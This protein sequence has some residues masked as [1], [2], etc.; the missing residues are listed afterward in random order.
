MNCT[1]TAKQQE[2][3]LI[4]VYRN[5]EDLSNTDKNFIL[6]DYIKE[7]HDLVLD[8]TKDQTLAYVY[9][10]I[11]PEF[12]S[13]AL[14][15]QRDLRSN[16]RKKGLNLEALDDKAQS[17]ED[18]ESVIS[19][20]I[21]KTDAP[22]KEEIDFNKK[23]AKQEKKKINKGP[24]LAELEKIN[25][26]KEEKQK[27]Q[28][29]EAL[30]NEINSIEH[31]KSSPL[32]T[33]GQEASIDENGVL[34]DNSDPRIK[35]IYDFLPVLRKAGLENGGDFDTLE[36]GG[37]TGFRVT[38]IKKSEIDQSI[39]HQR[40]KDLLEGK[41]FIAKNPT[42]AKKIYENTVEF[43]I[44]DLDGNILYF[45]KNN[46]IVEKEN[47]KPIYYP[48]PI[49]KY[50]NKK[51]K[52]SN[53]IDENK[54][55]TPEQ[56]AKYNNKDT[57]SELDEDYRTEL[58]KQAEEQQQLEIKSLYDL[59]KVVKKDPSNRIPLQITNIS[60][61][62][63]TAFAYKNKLVPVSDINFE[64][65]NLNKSQSIKIA[66]RDNQLKGEKNG[67][68][69]LT[70]PGQTKSI[71]LERV[72]RTKKEADT[73]A[74]LIVNDKLK[75]DG[76]PIESSEKMRLFENQ[77]VTSGNVI[78]MIINDNGDLEIKIR[79]KKL[80][81]S[82]KDEAKDILSKFLIENV[83]ATPEIRAENLKNYGD[84]VF[85][86]NHAEKNLPKDLQSEF[87]QFEIVKN[88]V[89]IKKVDPI[90]Y[91]IDNTKTGLKLDNNGAIPV[92][93][94]YVMFDVTEEDLTKENKNLE[95]QK[96][97]L[98][99]EISEVEKEIAKIE[100][101]GLDEKAKSETKKIVKQLSLDFPKAVNTV[102]EEEITPEEI[103][104]AAVEENIS[105]EEVKKKIVEEVD[106]ALQTRS[107]EDFAVEKKSDS[108]LKK[109]ARRIFTA[110]RN[111]IIA[112]V[113]YTGVTAASFEKGT[114]DFNNVIEHTAD[115]LNSNN[116]TSEYSETFI[117]AASK[118]GL[119]DM[120]VNESTIDISKVKEAQKVKALK[121][122]KDQDAIAKATAFRQYK[123][124]NT[125]FEKIDVVKDSHYKAR[126]GSK[127]NLLSAR[128]QWFNE[129]GFTYVSGA[130]Q[131]RMEDGETI[132]GVEGVAH[133][134]ILDD[135]GI[136]LSTK[137]SDK[138]L[139]AAS[140]SFKQNRIGKD[141][142]IT[143][144][145]P[146]FKRD[147][148]KVTV[149]YKVASEIDS[150]DITITRLH[151]YNFDDIDFK[152]K[153]SAKPFGFHGGG[154][155]A[156]TNKAG[157]G[158]PNFLFTSSGKGAYSRFSGGSYVLIFKDKQGNE[159]VH[160]VSGSLELL[161]K[162]GNDLAKSFGIKTSDIT[163]GIYDAGSYSAKPA[164]N[165][166]GVIETDQYRNYNKIHPHS[167]GALIFPKAPVDPV[168]AS[169]LFLSPLGI[170]R[171]KRKDNKKINNRDLQDLKD[172]KDELQNKLDLINKIMDEKVTVETVS[173]NPANIKDSDPSFIDPKINTDLNDVFGQALEKSKKGKKL[174]FRFEKLLPG[175][176]AKA[177][178]AGEWYNS[179]PFETLFP[180]K[181]AMHVANSNAYAT[182]TKHGV[183]L[184][185]GSSK[186][187]LY[188][189]AWH[190]FS[191]FFLTPEE[192]QSLYNE[193]ADTE[194]GHKALKKFARKQK[195]DVD[196]ISQNTKNLVM[197]EYLAED[198]RK[199]KLSN[200]KK[201][202]GSPIR[203][204][205]FKRILNFF[206]E[207]FGVG[208]IKPTMDINTIGRV[209]EFYD[210]L[211]LMDGKSL[212]N[213]S[214]SQ[215]NMMPGITSL[216]KGPIIPLDK[217]STDAISYSDAILVRK[218]FDSIMSS[219]VDQKVKDIGPH[220]AAAVYNQPELVLPALYQ[221]VKDLF[222]EKLADVESR[223]KTEQAKPSAPVDTQPQTSE[224][225]TYKGFV[226]IKNLK[227]NEDTVFGS[228]QDGFH[229]GGTAGILYANDSRAYKK[230]DIKGKGL[231][232]EVGK[233]KGFQTGT[234]GS[235]Y[236]LQTVTDW[237][238][239]MS[240]P[241]RQV[242]KAEIIEQIK[243]MYDYYKKNSNR[244][245]YVL[246]T[247]EGKN[248]NG[249]TS[250]EMAE[251]FASAGPIPS[252]VI[253]NEDLIAL[254]DITEPVS[255]VVA[256]STKN[257]IDPNKILQLTNQKQILNF[258][259]KNFGEP[260]DWVDAMKGVS[261]DGVVAYHLKKSE[262]LSFNP[263]EFDGN[264]V[265]DLAIENTWTKSS[266]KFSM[267]ELTSSQIRNLV[268][269]AKKYNQQ[270]EIEKNSLGFE[271][272]LDFNVAFKTLI[273]LTR[274]LDEPILMASKLNSVGG[275]KD[276][277]TW[278]K[279]NVLSKLG[280]VNNPRYSQNTMNLWTN[281]WQ[282][283]YKAYV[284]SYQLT[285]EEVIER[286]N[287]NT[288]VTKTTAKFGRAQG[289][290]KQVRFA[291]INEFKTTK[292]EF[293]I[294][295]EN[296]ANQLDVEGLKRKYKGST[297]NRKVEFLKDIGLPITDN[298][299]IKKGIDKVN[300]D[301]LYDKIIDYNKA[302]KDP[303]VDIVKVLTDSYPKAKINNKRKAL[304]S[305]ST[306]MNKLYDLEYKY[307]N[308]YG[309]DAEETPDGNRRYADV[310]NSTLTKKVQAFNKAKS[311]DD[312]VSMPYMSY[313]DPA[314]NTLTKNGSVWLNTIFEM[315]KPGK[316][317]RKDI[318]VKL[319]NVGGTILIR[320][321]SNDFD[322]STTSAKSDKFTRLMQDIYGL[323]MLGKPS[324]F[325]PADKSTVLTTSLSK[326]EIE[327]DKNKVS[328]HLY[329]DTADFLVSSK[330]NEVLSVGGVKAKNILINYIQAEIDRIKNIELG[331]QINVKGVTTDILN[332]DGTVKTKARAKDFQIFDGMFSKDVKKKLL[333]LKIPLDEYLKKDTKVSKNLS[334]LIDQQLAGFIETEVED[335]KERMGDL[336][337]FDS[338]IIS[339]LNSMLSQKNI[340]T[341]TVTKDEL[342]TYKRQRD[343]G[344]ISLDKYNKIVN[345]L[346]ATEK[347]VKETALLESYVMNLFI[348]NV[349]LLNFTFG[350]L[351][352]YKDF[353]KRNPGAQS[354]G[355][356]FRN[357]AIAQDYINETMFNT[358][359]EHFR[360]T[361]ANK[362]F[363][364]LSRVWDGVL[365][366]AVV[367][368]TVVES[369]LLPEYRKAFIDYYTKLYID[370]KKYTEKEALAKAKLS[371]EKAVDAYKNME[372]GDGQGWIT[373]DAYKMLSILQ[374]KW[375]PEQDK[376][377]NEIIAGKQLT[378]TETA[379]FFPARKYQYF[380]ELA[381]KG[382]PLT[383]FH[384]YS[385]MPLIPNVIDGTNMEVFHDNLVKQN[386]DYALHESGSKVSTI[387][388]E[389]S[390]MASQLWENF[391]DRVI[392]EDAVYENNPIYIEYLKDQLDINNKFKGGIPF[393]TQMRKLIEIGLMEDGLPTD[394][395]IGD[396]LEDREAAWNELSLAGKKK[397]SPKYTRV[398]EYEESINEHV[399]LKKEEILES[400]GSSLT[401]LR[402]GK[403]NMELIADVIIKEL[404]RQDMGIHELAMI[405]LN[406]TGNDFKYDLSISPS[407]EKIERVLT[408]FVNAKLITAKVNG[409]A[410]VQF[411]TTMMESRNATPEEKE[412]WGNSD[413]RGYRQ[414]F[415]KNGK[416]V[417][418]IGADAKIAL[419][420]DFV[421]LLQ[422]KGLDGKKVGVKDKD[423]N[424][425][426]KES[427][428]RLNALINN[429]AWRANENNLKLITIVGVRIPVQ[430]I[431]NMEFFHIKQ[432]LPKAAG[433]AIIPPSEIV[434][435]SGADFDIDKLQMMMPKIIINNGEVKILNVQTSTKSKSQIQ[436][437]I[438]INQ[439][440]KNAKA[441]QY[442]DKIKTLVD[443]LSKE[444]HREVSKT[445]YPQLNALYDN[446]DKVVYAYELAKAAHKK[447]T[448]YYTV[449]E[450]NRTEKNMN[451]VQ[452][453]I[454]D[455]ESLMTN[456]RSEIYYVVNLTPEIKDLVEARNE[457]L[458]K[459]SKKL[460]DYKELKESISS[461]AYDNKLMLDILNILQ[462][463]DN[464][465]HLIM[466]IDAGVAKEKAALMN[467]QFKD[468]N[469]GY[470]PEKGWKKKPGD[471]VK[472]TPG[473]ISPTKVLTAVFNNYMHDVNSIGKDS[474]GLG[475]IDNTF[476]VLANRIGLHMNPF[477][478][479]KEKPAGQ[480]VTD[481]YKILQK[482]RDDAVKVIDDKT[483]SKDQQTEANLMF[484]YA[485][486]ELD[487]VKQ[488]RMFLP[489]NSVK[490]D[491]YDVVSL[492]KLNDVNYEHNIGN[493]ISQL[494]NG[495]VDVAKGAWI[496]DI[497]G[498]KQISPVLLYMIQAGVPFSNA[499]DFLSNPLI[500]EYVDKQLSLSSPIAA[501]DPANE[502]IANMASEVSREAKNY[503]LE[504]YGSEYWK[505]DMY[506]NAIINPDAVYRLSLSLNNKDFN[507]KTL[508]KIASGKATADVNFKA[509]LHFLEIE[510]QSKGIDQL[511]LTLTYDT[512][513]TS[514]LFT[515]ALSESK[516]NELLE[517][518][519]IPSKLIEKFITDTP[520]GAFKIQGFITDLWSK[521]FKLKGHD[522]LTKF[523]IKKFNDYGSKNLM[524]ERFGTV[525]KYIETFRNDL[526]VYSFLEY[527][528]EFDINNIKGY[529]GLD[530]SIEESDIKNVD[531]LR[532]GV[533]VVKENGK[534]KI[535]LDKASLQDQFNLKTYSETD[536]DPNLNILNRFKYKNIY[537]L[538]SL[539][540]APVDEAAFNSNASLYYKFVIERELLRANNS[541]ADVLKLKPVSENFEASVKNKS[542]FPYKI[543][544]DVQE[545][546]K[547]RKIRLLKIAYENWLR[548]T[549]LRNNLNMYSLFRGK[550]TVAQTLKSIKNEYPH[551]E[552]M[553]GLLEELIVEEGSYASAGYK[554]FKLRKTKLTSDEIDSFH[555]NWLELADSNKIKISGNSAQAI[556][557]N[558]RIS[559]FFED[560]PIYGFLQAGLNVTDRFSVT[561]VM[562]FEKLTSFLV[563]VAEN[564]SKKLNN[565]YLNEYYASF[566]T[567]NFNPR[568]RRDKNYEFTYDLTIP[569]EAKG[570]ELINNEI[571]SVYKLNVTNKNELVDIIKNNPDVMFVVEK[572]NL[573]DTKVYVEGIGQIDITSNMQF[574]N[575]RQFATDSKK[576]YLQHDKQKENSEII[577][578]Q[579]TKIYDLWA[580][581]GNK[582][583][584]MSSGYG[585]YML[586][587]S[588]TGGYVNAT[589]YGNMSQ[590]LYDL[591]GYTNKNSKFFNQIAEDISLS[592]VVSDQSM[593]QS[594]NDELEKTLAEIDKC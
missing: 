419:Q 79:N 550:N 439:K 586:N 486:K 297:S 249:Y 396:T 473:V 196:T 137:T 124:D 416:V 523:L 302:F 543:I 359:G 118:L 326:I 30:E 69:Y 527:F 16:L 233:A 382:M 353:F 513:K 375:L 51:Y 319:D 497:Q 241:K 52:L 392:L 246:Y 38:P 182:W 272:L 420:G 331:N 507:D 479:F 144:Y 130:I 56:L 177:K 155:Y 584:F 296:G 146:V 454:E 151:Q 496:F 403:G 467:K 142:A 96:K 244:K 25:K 145:V 223:I 408:A 402:E 210:E 553:Y 436:D 418:N 515:S 448:N 104:Q 192:K 477:Y 172:Y 457:E 159:I 275:L 255:K 561:R 484:A 162:E 450:L 410:L 308:K 399:R 347:E 311:F 488:I 123:E 397:A 168:T 62:I 156:L 26:E 258:T 365:N 487:K 84:N 87:E 106:K 334:N 534:N 180:V 103:T 548:D 425:L 546:E 526:L 117:L 264:F 581:N 153:I 225:E 154:V 570:L 256:E 405:E 361:Y 563:D 148:N 41:E 149:N 200:G 150:S 583:A 462:D 254:V 245:A 188:H 213:Y 298:I 338:N 330:S 587:E 232:V 388:P 12:V 545:T 174:P 594:I 110:V 312:L 466:P 309:N 573:V 252:N 271:K 134:M 434:A 242:P 240:D 536:I 266:D 475:A 228:N 517:S 489:H 112:G 414:E 417:K 440:I 45:D 279:T 60:V 540:V 300:T 68:A 575:T 11:T 226:D 259:I 495:W 139:T 114:Y 40:D 75:F 332:E 355:Y 310:R 394:F 559:K 458:S 221:K 525:E 571:N 391:K 481:Y 381:T 490:Y 199:F 317:K 529:K 295:N 276:Q 401:D 203:N 565:T 88:K 292:G 122:K 202:L 140:K 175:Y 568:L 367:R 566:N 368:E 273:T 460:D 224:V 315:D 530:V 18:I 532:R 415:D 277:N 558:K 398:I 43:F 407:A 2:K 212:V 307:S 482:F 506:G 216:N 446:L 389:G 520:I 379:T 39:I 483:S 236:A 551:L 342:I 95:Q 13:L 461:K 70:L 59:Q 427:L 282:T 320:N 499:V 204:S 109:L 185:K 77:V 351:S 169:L 50:E 119:Y 3:F 574:L 217:N 585:E 346:Q 363:P 194:V 108:F 472:D 318:S 341:N 593:E 206:K 321:E 152:S 102:I 72:G 369:Y 157:V 197:E 238:L 400:L 57:W 121:V 578:G 435:K 469:I 10:Q 480:K 421:K 9:A 519:M 556:A 44:T 424:I 314:R 554:N 395:N 126:K 214:P 428:D 107:D 234:E 247:T 24:S 463:P 187:D 83:G 81:L 270:G 374:G 165:T 71:K 67:W 7:I 191:Q 48:M 412:K 538:N 510:E 31:K 263:K 261:E 94:G 220:V 58:I 316:P 343:Y 189:E 128:N 230:Q 253:F 286:L 14:T 176:K 329:I 20:P 267:S 251:M 85:Y 504:T 336:M 501:L 390:E 183:T 86:E 433:T 294:Q 61:G 207:F 76:K 441:K 528:N 422:L 535:Y 437:F 37:H 345:Q 35:Y 537:N 514:S 99:K 178:K 208:T 588:E 54:L 17:F 518:T 366:T 205:I 291:F 370:S 572:G 304:K 471:S 376:L 555:D 27:K 429:E 498:N 49:A 280:P 135:L 453:K 201:V 173:E 494:M 442:K 468:S 356:Q 522:E 485:K 423:G 8:I 23:H 352:Q 237:K 6:D 560:L 476:N 385:L 340:V 209:K 66:E 451:T 426:E 19:D 132:S 91:I 15:G 354:D 333:A 287:D 257:T 21:F 344:K 542:L 511:K 274:N 215:L 42:Q 158:M 4:K 116:L 303:I 268:F 141:I 131:S 231:R 143:D 229:G 508:H 465:V 432:F 93:N 579:L 36:L 521:R 492:S 371:A 284:P 65:S 262:F 170:V 325:T 190:G 63:P 339:N 34:Q 335:I 133:F 557:E 533:A 53:R 323:L 372:E 452:L 383:A 576:S 138:E 328:N 493:L 505:K 589:I 129:D 171:K 211:N 322:F 115:I 592:Q 181:M 524:K 47:G 269:G 377:Y 195:V 98:E 46:N 500:L 97:D 577:K 541:T 281:F 580:N 364:K 357:D 362:M 113:M 127:D 562:P 582:V 105:E 404:D 411:S 278:I 549:A 516:F 406:E 285:V 193:V 360:Q 590:A 380:G 348:H 218:S 260:K 283:F 409:E 22:T 82:K 28:A 449:K 387:Y 567:K 386:I 179:H 78:K 227:D 569:A 64:A 384:K 32:G 443:K 313:L 111:L 349:E 186:T 591:F 167:G 430:G 531:V 564:T 478:G 305:E 219:V 160:D 512:T 358:T 290:F 327:N 474:L 120:S 239:S 5:L 459:L 455:L 509:F 552:K 100:K 184:Y 350:D 125:Y 502:S 101:E 89:I 539:G 55:M 92:L 445:Y 161:E 491:G 163:L 306:N 470:N 438:D 222:V 265:E 413:L 324:N 288:S 299:I 166:E 90:Q 250:L 378:L 1:L 337:Y 293:I 243:D 464:F 80:D 393:S 373:F 74:E 147:S 29:D 444:A 456:V 73:L 248:L 164:A 235:S 503:I 547:E 198:F 447:D 33:T 431:N 544:N 136:D 289:A 301:M